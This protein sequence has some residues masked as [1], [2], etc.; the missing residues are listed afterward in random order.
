V[1]FSDAVKALSSI[2][3]SYE[4]VEQ[5]IK[6]EFTRVSPRK[7]PGIPLSSDFEVVSLNEARSVVGI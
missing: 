6:M 7:S 5:L 2:V 3:N 1:A 4:V